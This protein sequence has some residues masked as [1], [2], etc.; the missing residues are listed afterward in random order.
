MKASAQS[1]PLADLTDEIKAHGGL[2]RTTSTDVDEK[3][4]RFARFCDSHGVDSMP[5]QEET[6]LAFLASEAV[7]LRHNS[8]RNLVVRI[9]EAHVANGFPWPQWPRVTFTLKA[10]RRSAPADQPKVKALPPDVV[11]RMAE[12]LTMCPVAVGPPDEQYVRAALC[13]ARLSAASSWPQIRVDRLSLGADGVLTHNGAQIPGTV[14]TAAFPLLVGAT[15]LGPTTS[16]TEFGAVRGRIMS[17][18][19]RAGLTLSTPE[20]VRNLSEPDFH[21][22]LIHCDKTYLRRTRDLVWL[23]LGIYAG[24]RHIS[25]ANLDIA[26]IMPTADGYRAT[27]RLAK[28]RS[29]DVLY[30]DFPHLTGGGT[31]CSDVL[32]PACALARQLEVCRRHGRTTGPLLATRY[33]GRWRVMTRQNGK[34]L[35]AQLWRSAAGEESARIATRSLRRTAATWACEA[36][37]SMAEASASITNH[38]D[39]DTFAGYVELTPNNEA[40]PGYEF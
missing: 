40:H 12:Q 13:L 28:L 15:S 4:A 18:A 34:F 5:C 27:F 24:L 36:G 6:V 17:A 22:L 29:G 25:L 31:D 26:D 3:M 8:A 23:T 21:S 30:R 7:N 39:V 10:L 20:S 9:Q 33:G 14:D 38:K 37:L 1:S 19:R 11:E 16:S 35:I 2:A 32:C